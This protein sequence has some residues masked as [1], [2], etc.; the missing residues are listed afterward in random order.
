MLFYK[1]NELAT[2]WGKT[3]HDILHMILE[4]RMAWWL[5]KP[6]QIFTNGPLKD[7][8]ELIESAQAK[9]FIIRS[10]V[11]LDYYYGKGDPC[12]YH[13]DDFVVFPEE[14]E[15]VEREI[16]ELLKSNSLKHEAP[17]FSTDSPTL[18]IPAAP[19][20]MHVTNDIAASLTADHIPEGKKRNEYAP[21]ANTEL[22]PIDGQDEIMAFLDASWNTCKAR[23]AEH[24]ISRPIEGKWQLPWSIALKIKAARGKK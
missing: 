2:K 10:S 4:G 21:N 23:M 19:L 1:I 15:R 6:V 9:A 24:G 7:N 11:P 16:P 14:V 12:R 5:P 18:N 8:Y 3:E 20:H 22:P 17:P 13:L